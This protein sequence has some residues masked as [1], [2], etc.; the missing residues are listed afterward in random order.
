[1]HK[2]SNIPLYIYV[3]VDDVLLLYIIF[4]KLADMLS[5]TV[6]DEILVRVIFGEIVQNT[7]WRIKYWRI[8]HACI[9]IP[10]QGYYWWMKYWRFD[11]KIANRQSL[12]LANISSYTVHA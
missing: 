7:F 11:S 4:S 3:F 12:F 10:V 6:L 8:P 1:M 9:H 5:C 2:N